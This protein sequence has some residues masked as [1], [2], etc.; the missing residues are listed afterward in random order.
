MIRRQ[1]KANK[2]IKEYKSFAETAEIIVLMPLIVLGLTLTTGLTPNSSPFL[3]CLGYG[4]AALASISLLIMHFGTV[5]IKRLAWAMAIIFWSFYMTYETYYFVRSGQVETLL[6]SV[7]K[8]FVILN[9]F[10]YRLISV[11]CLKCRVVKP[12]KKANRKS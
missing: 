1:D 4:M 12:I 11:H 5:Q 7:P 3:V 9:F 6:L 2:P 10:I 8:S